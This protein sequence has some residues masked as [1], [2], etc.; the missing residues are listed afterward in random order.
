MAT[1]QE[2]INT[3]VQHSLLSCGVDKIYDVISEA[4]GRAGQMKWNGRFT[5]AVFCVCACV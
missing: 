1:E 2:Q 4:D 5:V 3:D